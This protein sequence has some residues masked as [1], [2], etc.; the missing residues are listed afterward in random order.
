MPD[1]VAE[2]LAS[3]DFIHCLYQ[4]KSHD[5]RDEER[6]IGLVNIWCDDTFTAV[7]NGPK[8]PMAVIGFHLSQEGFYVSQMQ[9]IRGVNTRGVDI[10]LFLIAKAEIMARALDKSVVYI[11]SAY[12]NLYWDLDEEHRLYP[13]LYAHRDRLRKIYDASAAKMGYT[14]GPFPSSSWRKVIRKKITFRRW[15]RLQLV[16][17]N[18][19]CL[20]RYNYVDD[21]ADTNAP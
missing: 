13:Q 19:E 21:F 15:W 6:L 3:L 9:G 16:L 18:R 1:V 10:G 11:A 8:G 7:I 12:S 4:G 5:R 2:R 14:A 20:K 17:Y